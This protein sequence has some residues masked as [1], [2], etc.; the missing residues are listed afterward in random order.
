M[1]WNVL[2]VEVTFLRRHLTE[3]DFLAVYVIIFQYRG[4]GKAIELGETKWYY[5][6]PKV[7]SKTKPLIRDFI[8]NKINSR[9]KYDY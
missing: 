3:P 8:N 7:I 9:K 4:M 1:G 2:E 6:F 5:V